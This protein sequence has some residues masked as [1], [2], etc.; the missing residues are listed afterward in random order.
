MSLPATK[1]KPVTNRARNP[2]QASLL[3]DTILHRDE[4]H[5]VMG[6]WMGF[7]PRLEQEAVQKKIYKILTE[8]KTNEEE[9]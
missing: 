3:A 7:I 6:K 1:I 4:I 9:A 2:E 8:E 5:A